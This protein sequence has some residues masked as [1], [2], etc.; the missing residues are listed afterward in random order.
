MSLVVVDF[1]LRVLETKSSMFSFCTLFLSWSIGLGK[2]LAS[3]STILLV[4]SNSRTVFCSSANPT[5][6]FFF[7]LSS[8]DSSKLASSYCR[9]A[10]KALASSSSSR[11]A[12]IPLD[13][14]LIFFFFFLSTTSPGGLSAG[15]FFVEV[16]DAWMG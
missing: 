4:L 16:E 2:S 9:S 13:F 5:D 15:S 8:F 14:F 1:F 6:F 7:G 12:S 3:V 10:A 11:K